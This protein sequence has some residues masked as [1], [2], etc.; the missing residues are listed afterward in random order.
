MLGMGWRAWTG[1]AGGGAAGTLC[2]PAGAPGG[3]GGACTFGVELEVTYIWGFN[4]EA[5]Q[6]AISS[7][8]LGDKKLFPSLL[9]L[10]LEGGQ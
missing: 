5:I 10:L 2:G 4:L 3:T 9:T 7:I 6:S 8:S 1:T